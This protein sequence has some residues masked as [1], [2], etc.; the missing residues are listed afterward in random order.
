MEKE[1]R[2]RPF[3]FTRFCRRKDCPAA[4][5]LFYLMFRLRLHGPTGLQTYRE[6]FTSPSDMLPDHSE[7]AIPVPAGP[8]E[9]RP[10][11]PAM[12]CRDSLTR[13]A[14]HHEVPAHAP[15]EPSGFSTPLGKTRRPRK[16]AVPRYGQKGN[17]ND[18]IQ[19]IHKSRGCHRPAN[20]I[21]KV[22][23]QDNKNSEYRHY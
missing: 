8:G 13:T 1:R 15:P 23:M 20:T 22:I 10:R 9:G 6:S 2:G 18:K 14:H 12:A 3:S 11:L 5:L 7:K 21:R 17:K 16:T 19:R 4:A